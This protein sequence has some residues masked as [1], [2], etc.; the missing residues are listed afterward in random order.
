MKLVKPLCNKFLRLMGE[1]WMS[2]GD[3]R[4]SSHDPRLPQIA[5][6]IVVPLA[7]AVSILTSHLELVTEQNGVY[8][9]P[10]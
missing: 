5:H 7:G 6:N 4:D 1:Y 8:V 3:H 10:I 9:R 2:N